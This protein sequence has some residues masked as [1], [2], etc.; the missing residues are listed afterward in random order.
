MNNRWLS[1]AAALLGLLAA[2]ALA[3]AAVIVTTLP[4]PTSQPNNLVLGSDGVSGTILASRTLAF[5]GTNPNFHGTVTEAVIRDVTTGLL[6]FVYQVHTDATATIGAVRFTTNP[7][8]ATVNIGAPPQGTV[9]PDGPTAFGAGFTTVLNATLTAAGF[10]TTTAG[11]SPPAADRTSTTIGF[12]RTSGTELPPGAFG[13]ILFVRTDA[14][15]FAD[16]GKLDLIDGSIAEINAWVPVAV[17][18]PS[19]VMAALSGL[20]LC[21]LAGWRRRFRKVS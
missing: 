12:Q 2:P 17:P 14:T 16:I 19:T 3:Q 20:A 8:A 15:A 6:D 11:S 4:S 13:N 1:T 7:F 5:L 21:G 18:E 10:T 9:V